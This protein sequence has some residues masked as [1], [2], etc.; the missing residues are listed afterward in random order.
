[1]KIAFLS[2]SPLLESGMGRAHR[3]LLKSFS[4]FGYEVVSLGWHHKSY[5]S[6]VDRVYPPVDWAVYGCSKPTPYSKDGNRDDI[7]NFLKRERPDILITLGDVWDFFGAIGQ[8]ERNLWVLYC[9]VDSEPFD[10]RCLPVFLNSDVQITTSKWGADVIR[11]D[12]GFVADYAHHGYDPFVFYDLGIKVNERKLVDVSGRLLRDIKNKFVVLMDSWN[13]YR[14]NYPIALEILNKFGEDKDDVFFILITDV[15]GKEGGGYDI[16]YGM[17]LIYP[18]LKPKLVV[19][20]ISL[21]NSTT[22]SDSTLNYVYNLADVYLSTARAEGFGLSLLQAMATRTIPV[23]PRY[24]SH[25]E[26]LGE[27]RGELIDIASYDRDRGFRKTAIVDVDS[28]VNILNFIYKKWRYRD[29]NYFVSKFNA[30]LKFCKENTWDNSARRILDI[31]SK[32][33]EKKGRHFFRANTRNVLFATEGFSPLLL[34]TVVRNINKSASNSPHIGVFIFGGIG[35]NLQGVPVIKGILRTYPATACLHIIC[36]GNGYIFRDVFADIY[37]QNRIFIYETKTSFNSALYSLGG[38]AFD[39]LYDVRYVSAVYNRDGYLE[40]ELPQNSV[41][42]FKRNKYFY[43]NW[44]WGNNSIYLLN[45]HVIGLKLITT[46]LDGVASISDMTYPCREMPLPGKKYV[47]MLNEGGSL[48]KYKKISNK[49]ISLVAAAIKKMGFNVVFVGGR[50]NKDSEIPDCAIDLRGRTN[51]PQTAYLLKNA[52]ITI[53][54]EG[55]IYHLAKAVN[56]RRAVWFTNVHPEP[57]LY[58]DDNDVLLTPARTFEMKCPPCWWRGE[59]FLRGEC[60]WGK[61][62]EECANAP[63][64]EYMIEKVRGALG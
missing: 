57:F 29:Y 63:D 60:L 12:S 37:S 26:L 15:K 40:S 35:D 47:V 14:K 3:Y 44:A 58:N 42:F 53:C 48:G 8:S 59:F 41:D 33:K 5:A 24:A 11:R 1:M 13:C 55:G 6:K 20:D 4:H 46:G 7:A 32:K 51:L 45:R 25:I 38:N 23:A 27:N 49:K 31:I 10:L 18:D 50:G 28:A 17:D 39:Y 2:D 22:L 54:P 43:D 64:V 52:S 21:K 19:N 30:G 36:E 56:G 61:D 34:S 16:E 9:N 62:A